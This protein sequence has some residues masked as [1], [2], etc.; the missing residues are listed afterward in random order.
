MNS[1]KNTVKKQEKV[2]FS[3][4]ESICDFKWI[5]YFTKAWHLLSRITAHFDYINAFSIDFTQ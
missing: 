5:S 1:K 3:H 2:K 4:F